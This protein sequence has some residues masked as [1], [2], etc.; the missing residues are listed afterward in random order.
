MSTTL[1]LLNAN[2]TSTA[3]VHAAIVITHACAGA[4]WILVAVPDDALTR[5]ARRHAARTLLVFALTLAL[6][7]VAAAAL[8]LASS[9]R[10]TVRVVREALGPAGVALAASP[11]VWLVAWTVQVSSRSTA[12][13]RTAGYTAAAVAALGVFLGAAVAALL[14]N[15]AQW[16]ESHAVRDVML[17]GW[18]IPVLAVRVATALTI[19]GAA[20]WAW[21]APRIDGAGSR[22]IVIGTVVSAI[23]LAAAMVVLW[24]GASSHFARNAWL[25]VPTRLGAHAE[26]AGRLTFV[27]ALLA[28]LTALTLVAARRHPVE[29]LAPVGALALCCAALLCFERARH[30]AVLPWSVPGVVFANGTQAERVRL[31]RRSARLET[32]SGVADDTVGGAMF[33]VQCRACHAPVELRAKLGDRGFPATRAFLEGLREADQVGNVWRGVMPPLVGN[34]REVESL[35]RWASSPR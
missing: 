1:D 5:D 25:E 19:G 8:A 30:A 32:P 28:T 35:A 29:R 22:R 13:A 26:Q 10:E 20:A 33:S 11:A 7:V 4:G 9:S 24:I 3:I 16:I 14:W 2:G 18:V 17:S 15:P 12:I 6:P 34:D 21:M 27:A 23:V 31:A